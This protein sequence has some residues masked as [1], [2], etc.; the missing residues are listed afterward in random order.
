MENIIRL[1]TEN[2]FSRRISLILLVEVFE[3]LFCKPLAKRS[4]TWFVVKP[5]YFKY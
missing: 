1:K 5:V 3:D 4:L 2:T